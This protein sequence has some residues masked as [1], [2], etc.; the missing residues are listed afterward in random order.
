MKIADT[1]IY[2]KFIAWFLLVAILPLILLFAILFQFDLSQAET[3]LIGAETSNI[4]FGLFITLA[5]VLILALVAARILSQSITSP[6]QFSVEDLLRVVKNLDKSINNLSLASQDS[7]QVV[8]FLSNSTRQQQKG[9][10]SGHQSIGKIAKSLDQIVNKVNIT[11]QNT[12]SI[13]KLTDESEAKVQ[14]GLG[15]LL[16]VKQLSTE[17]QKLTQ[18]LDDYTERVSIIAQRVESMAD[19]AKYLSL[20]ATIEA[21]KTNI[22]EEFSGIVNQIRQLNT[23]SQQAAVGIKDLTGNMQRQIEQTKKLQFMVCKKQ[24]RAS[25]LSV[26]A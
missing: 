16:A 13:D 19:L 20:N 12:A 1:K 23:I 15:S 9:L 8:K 22:S 4:L 11:T 26:R 14:A 3:A 25:V 2:L 7:R 21:N 5:L 18:A 17:N 24:K 6:V 10:D